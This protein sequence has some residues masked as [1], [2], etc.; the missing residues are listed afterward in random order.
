MMMMMMMMMM[1]TKK[2]TNI[3][4]DVCL[5]WVLCVV[6]YRSL[7][8]ADRRPSR[9]FLP[10]CDVSNYRA[11]TMNRP[12]P[13]KGYYATEKEI[14]AIINI[15]LISVFTNMAMRY[16][17]LNNFCCWCRYF[18][19]LTLSPNISLQNDC[20]CI[21]PL[22]NV[23]FWS[24]HIRSITWIRWYFRANKS[25]C[26]H[27]DKHTHSKPTHQAKIQR[28][29]WNICFSGTSYTFVF[30]IIPFNILLR[31]KL[32]LRSNRSQSRIAPW[33][34]LHRI[35]VVQ[36]YRSFYWHLPSRENYNGD[37]VSVTTMNMAVQAI[38]DLKKAVC[39]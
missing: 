4:V 15:T 26:T 9:W 28:K 13:A 19:E 11:S 34:N 39:F 27:I 1:I 20:I 2:D 3:Y 30:L 25:Q 16:L 17:R 10:G 38:E 14:I 33:R 23:V 8:R 21:F 24:E 7:W 5:L 6:R 18:T 29:K 31:L 37:S 12:W 22:S 36:V 35:P 32:R